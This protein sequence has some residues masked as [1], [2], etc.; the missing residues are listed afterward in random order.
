MLQQAAQYSYL[1]TIPG[2]FNNHGT[3]RAPLST[4]GGASNWSTTWQWL[5]LG[6]GPQGKLPA[7]LGQNPH[8]SHLRHG[9]RLLWAI[10]SKPGSLDHWAAAMAG[11]RAARGRGVYQFS[12]GS[13]V[14]T[15]DHVAAHSGFLLAYLFKTVH[16]PC[17]Q[18]RASSCTP[19]SLPSTISIISTIKNESSDPNVPCPSVEMPGCISLSRLGPKW[20]NV[21][22]AENSQD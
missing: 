3:C 10:L 11:Q 1:W 4:S 18:Y 13:T 15:S 19:A 2:W 22:A 14:A 20:W 17:E 7:L 8:F 5:E 6:L 21:H 16:C 9:C 12:G